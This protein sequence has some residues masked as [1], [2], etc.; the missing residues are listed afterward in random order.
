MTRRIA[1]DDR[2]SSPN[3]IGVCDVLKEEMAL[4]SLPVKIVQR[5]SVVTAQSSHASS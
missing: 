2:A 4:L 5:H 1:E 3:E